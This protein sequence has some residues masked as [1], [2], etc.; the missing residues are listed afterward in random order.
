MP[1]DEVLSQLP[2]WITILLSLAKEC[3][4]FKAQAP[5]GVQS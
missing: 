5:E 4:Q 2:R 1:T 3:E